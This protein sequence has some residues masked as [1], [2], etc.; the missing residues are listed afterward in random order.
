MKRNSVTNWDKV[1]LPLLTLFFC[2]G[3]SFTILP[4]QAEV[5]YRGNEFSISPA[6]AF[7]EILTYDDAGQ[8]LSHGSTVAVSMPDL[9]NLIY[10][11][12]PFD[13]Q[14]ETQ[15]FHLTACHVLR[16]GKTIILERGHR[17][18]VADLVLAY[19]DYDLCILSAPPGFHAAPVKMAKTLPGS[20]EP[21]WITGFK[22]GDKVAIS[23]RYFAAGQLGRFPIA[24]AAGQ[25][26]NGMSGGAWFNAAGEV[27]AISIGRYPELQLS[28]GILLPDVSRALD[29]EALFSENNAK[30]KYNLALSEIN[31]VPSFLDMGYVWPALLALRPEIMLP[32]KTATKTR[33]LGQ[34]D[35]QR[36][37]S[38]CKIHYQNH[39][40]RNF[41]LSLEYGEAGSKLVLFHPHIQRDF[42]MNHIMI[43]LE[44]AGDVFALNRDLSGIYRNDEEHQPVRWFM[45]RAAGFLEALPGT[46]RLIIRLDGMQ[47]ETVDWPAQVLWNGIRDTCILPH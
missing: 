47:T 31:A 28:A 27:F 35:L 17:R 10:Q 46:Q 42:A 36:S 37:P 44:P 45:H 14:E 30:P 25:V 1:F 11:D 40:N 23:A 8:L 32:P 22:E 18:V 3:C 13:A 7:A 12:K 4:L 39:L 15:L 38:S 20:D 21:I 19:Q 26:L 2:L 6:R 43:R 41:H 16:N 29:L 34:W 24:I 5:I 9:H 33:K